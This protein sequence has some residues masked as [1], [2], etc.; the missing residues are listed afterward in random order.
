MG[1]IHAPSSR[2]RTGIFIS[3]STAAETALTTHTKQA[4]A[5]QLMTSQTMGHFGQQSDERA[6]FLSL[7]F[8]PLSAPLRSRWRNNGVSADFL[9]DYVITF[10]PADGCMA[11]SGNKQIEIR[12][13]V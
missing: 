2:R 9:G 5:Q 1:Q 8:S 13:A 3:P 10:L 7:S 11:C 4:R 6:E 12:H